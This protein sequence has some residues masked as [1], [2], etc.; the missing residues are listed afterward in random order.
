[1]DRSL[2]I[3][4]SV[5]RIGVSQL[6]NRDVEIIVVLIGDDFD[7]IELVYVMLYIGNIIDVLIDEDLNQLLV[8]IVKLICIGWL[9]I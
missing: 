6:E 5:L 9:S 3:E 7:I 8:E 1:M 2:G 4:E